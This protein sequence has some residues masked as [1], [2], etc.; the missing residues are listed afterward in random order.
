MKLTPRLKKNLRIATPFLLALLLAIAILPGAVFAQPPGTPGNGGGTPQ[1]DPPAA[2][3]TPNV[4]VGPPPNTENRR[5]GGWPARQP[6]AHRN[7]GRNRDA[8]PVRAATSERTLH[9]PG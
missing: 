7:P 8:R 9:A 3:P 5:P 6:I 1:G 2:T 4:P